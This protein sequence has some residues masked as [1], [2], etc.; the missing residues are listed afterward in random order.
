MLTILDMRAIKY[1]TELFHYSKQRCTFR[2]TTFSSVQFSTKQR[3][4]FSPTTFSS[5]QFSSV[6]FSSV[7]Y[8]FSSVH[9]IKFMSCSIAR[10]SSARA[11]GAS[12]LVAG[13]VGGGC[14]P[15]NSP[16]SKR[17]RRIWACRGLDLTCLAAAPPRCGCC[18]QPAV[19]HNAVG[20]FSLHSWLAGG[21]GAAVTP[22]I[23]CLTAFFHLV[24]QISHHYLGASWNY[25]RRRRPATS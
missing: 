6:Q 5:V 20:Q 11:R 1:R 25:D 7:H 9:V 10:E 15:L 23:I 12:A 24:D 3:C 2:P 14:P 21:A 13:A 8:T 18:P 17:R 16:C 22:H 19:A 4:T